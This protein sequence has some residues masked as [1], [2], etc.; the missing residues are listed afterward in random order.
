MMNT[1]RLRAA[2]LGCVLIASPGYAQQ[3][4]QAPPPSDIGS[5]PGTLSEKLNETSGVIHPRGG[6][7]PEMPST[8]PETGTMPVVPPPGSPGGRTDVVP[9]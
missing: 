2:V 1:W 8:P 3:T 9:K 5:H 4:G 6:V 7:D